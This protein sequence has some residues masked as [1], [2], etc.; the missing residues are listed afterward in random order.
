MP[1]YKIIYTKLKECT[2]KI[3]ASNKE[4]AESKFKQ[5]WDI[6]HNMECVNVENVLEE[7]E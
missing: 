2:K 6:L 7:I 3:T 4:E 5:W 1:K